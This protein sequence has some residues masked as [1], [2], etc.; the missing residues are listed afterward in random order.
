M[1]KI[2]ERLEE[3]RKELTEIYMGLGNPG[4][5]SADLQLNQDITELEKE[6]EK[7]LPKDAINGSKGK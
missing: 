5:I 1:K 7:S 2:I 4:S 3:I 6:Y